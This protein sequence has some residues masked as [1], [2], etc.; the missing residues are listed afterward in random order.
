MRRVSQREIYPGLTLMLRAAD[1]GY[2]EA[3]GW[4]PK[5]RSTVELPTMPT[6]APEANGSDRWAE[7][8]WMQLSE[9]TSAVVAKSAELGEALSLPAR[10]LN[11]VTEG[12]RWHDLGKAHR[13]FQ[14]SVRRNDMNAPAG[15]L[16]KGPH[17]IRHE[18]PG[19]RH[20]LASGV[21]ALMHGKDDLVAYLAAS[22]HGKVRLSIRSMPNERRPLDPTTC[23]A[24]GIFEGE[25]I[26][27]ANLGGG[28]V[29]PATIIDLSYMEFGRK[30]RAWAKL[31]C[32]NAQS[33]GSGRLWAFPPRAAR[34]DIEGGG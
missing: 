21:L 34:S 2:T 23:F 26:P 3:E 11:A 16:A 30:S 9:H 15:L 13:V 12:A 22:H 28:V 5:S 32:S 24:R 19:F 14:N 31:A 8:D 27:E 10:L 4:N 7:T 18:R 6:E 33:T 29:V 25:L 1:G 20:E 17:H